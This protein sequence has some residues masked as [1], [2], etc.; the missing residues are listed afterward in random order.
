MIGLF[1]FVTVVIG[2]RHKHDLP[3]YLTP[4]KN[5]LS[6]TSGYSTNYTHSSIFRTTPL[7]KTCTNARI[8][9][10]TARSEL[11]SRAKECFLQQYSYLYY[12][13]GSEAK[14]NIS[15]QCTRQFWSYYGIDWCSVAIQVQYFS[16]IQS[17]LCN[18]IPVLL[19]NGIIMQGFEVETRRQKR[20]NS[21]DLS[22][23]VDVG[24]E[25]L[26]II[27]RFHQTPK[28][29]KIREPQYQALTIYGTS[30]FK[31]LAFK[32]ST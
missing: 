5:S 6:C 7:C 29:A 17:I 1:D 31:L 16:V 27:Q 32:Q 18:M 15:C 21:T 22:P 11:W 14:K 10:N 12:R 26:S 28:P 13:E 3:V 30:R 9:G 19:K 8:E 4:V 24:Q 25:N 23:I 20:R 2:Q